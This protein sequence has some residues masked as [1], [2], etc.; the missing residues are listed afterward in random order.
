MVLSKTPEQFTGGTGAREQRERE[1]FGV[2]YSVID[3]GR[4]EEK[5]P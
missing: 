3:D 4:I 2:R 5:H 1:G